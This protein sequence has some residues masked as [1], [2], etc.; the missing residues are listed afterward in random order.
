MYH[1]KNQWTKTNEQCAITN[2]QWSMGNNQSAMNA[3]KMDQVRHC[4]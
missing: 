2:D 1:N 4:E 3:Q